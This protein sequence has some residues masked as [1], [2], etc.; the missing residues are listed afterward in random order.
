MAPEAIQTPVP[1]TLTGTLRG[2]RDFS[3]AMKEGSRDGQVSWGYPGGSTGYNPKCRHRREEDVQPT[4]EARG[5]RDEKRGLNG[6][7]TGLLEAPKDLFLPWNR[8]CVD[9]DLRNRREQTSVVLSRR[10]RLSGHRK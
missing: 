1:G 5:W 8:L 2:K 4:T 7:G 3:D 6:G 10:V 9:S